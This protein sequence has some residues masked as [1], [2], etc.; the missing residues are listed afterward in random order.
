VKIGGLIL[1]MFASSAA[2]ADCPHAATLVEQAFKLPVRDRVALLEAAVADCPS[3][4]TAEALGESYQA[5]E[6]W[7]QAQKA[8]ALANSRLA[9]EPSTGREHQR[10][11]LL[12]R[13]AQ[14]AQG[15]HHL[16][17]AVAQYSDAARLFS[18]T[19]QSEARSGMLRAES[20]WTQGG[21]G[22]DDIACALAAQLSAQKDYCEESSCRLFHDASVDIPVQFATD[23]ADL[24]PDSSKQVVAIAAGVGP[25]IQQGYRLNITGHTDK[26]GTREH[27]SKL[28]RERAHRVA[29]ALAADL[30]IPLADIGVEGKGFDAPKYPGD[31]ADALRLNRRVEVALKPKAAAKGFSLVSAA[32]YE[33]L[34][35]GK[36]GITQFEAETREVA[37]ALDLNAPQI[38]VQSPDPRAEI[39]PPL[40]LELRFKP[41]ADAQI[42]VSSF[43]VIYKF[44]LL[45]KDI[46]DRI[47]PFLSLTRDG[48]TGASA[49]AIPAGE[50][51]LIIRIRDSL[52]R[53]GEQTVTFRIGASQGG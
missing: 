38:L 10:A 23:S 4:G 11:L 43:Q 27:N 20:E 34:K 51:T 32:E 33:Q 7:D 37:K 2:G 19:E 24:S 46:T 6:E 52:H 48:A 8:Y 16:C 3:F 41:A 39:H 14:I 9:A 31:S 35:S 5:R 47:L 53:T 22:A 30:G 1:L 45:R 26:R 13:S 17:R 50:H 28:S 49:A 40:K 15:Q 21:L 29:V 25:F 36:P 42:D 18:G 12:F 44:G